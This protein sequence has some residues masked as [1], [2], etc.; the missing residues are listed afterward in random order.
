MSFHG[1]YGPLEELDAW[2]SGGL[3]GAGLVVVVLLALLLGLRHATDPDHLFAV[4]A[5]LS[6]QEAGSREAIRLGAWWGTGHATVLVALG[7]PLILLERG[8]PGSVEVAAE[9]TVGVVIMLLAA[10]VLVRWS[11]RRR[12]PAGTLGSGAHDVPP[13]TRTAARSAAIGVVHGLGGTGAI[14]LLLLA[15]LPST[16]Q[17]AVA[18]CAF[19]PMSVVS[20]ALCTGA[21]AWVLERRGLAPAYDIVG[22]PLLALVTLAFGG[23]YAGLG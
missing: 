22:M 5:L 7:L 11:R 18:L 1:L 8:M 21:Y 12:R 4:T 16:A 6:G 17:A 3:D 20:M 2:L 13:P 23:W 14:A 9:K 15:A 19:A 10:R